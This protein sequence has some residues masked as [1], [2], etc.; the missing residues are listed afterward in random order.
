MANQGKTL[1][2]LPEEYVITKCVASG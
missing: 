1:F 2:I